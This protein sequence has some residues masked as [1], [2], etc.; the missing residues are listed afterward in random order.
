MSV[1][2]AQLFC[3]IALGIGFISADMDRVGYLGPPGTHGVSWG[4]WENFF[5]YSKNLMYYLPDSLIQV[6]AVTASLAELVFGLALIFGLFTRTTSILSGILLLCF[7]LAM[8][9]SMGLHAPLSYSV[10]TASAAAFLL[11]V[12]D[13][14]RWSIDAMINKS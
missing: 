4:N 2:Y 11:S 10:Y 12:V 9:F 6:F 3:R 8:T 14:Y 1:A 13:N 7:A 5:L